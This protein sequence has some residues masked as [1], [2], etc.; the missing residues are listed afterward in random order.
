MKNDIVEKPII[1]SKIEKTVEASLKTSIKDLFKTEQLDLLAKLKEKK[2]FVIC[3]VG[4][5]GSGKTT[6]IAKIA[7]LL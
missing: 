5:N 3:F 4:I 6:T 1:R 2:P 7:K